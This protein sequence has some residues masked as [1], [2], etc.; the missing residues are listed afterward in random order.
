MRYSG[1]GWTG[2][3][4]LGEL[5]LP[6]NKMGP[7]DNPETF[8]DLFESK[9]KGMW[10]A[11]NEMGMAIGQLLLIYWGIFVR[12]SLGKKKSREGRQ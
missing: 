9:S 12:M 6:L 10:V 2:R 8:I 4:E 7:Q 1:A 3:F 5:H 11:L